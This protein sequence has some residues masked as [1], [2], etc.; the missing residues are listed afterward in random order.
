MA[1]TRGGAIA[2]RS[3]TPL[4][5]L[6]VGKLAENLLFVENCLSKNAQLGAEKLPF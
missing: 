5:I 4:K 2:L 6:A 3:P 1:E